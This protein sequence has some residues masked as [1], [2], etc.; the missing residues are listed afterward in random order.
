MK[1]DKNL[2]FWVR[3]QRP[4]SSDWRSGDFG[5]GEPHPA[6]VGRRCAKYKGGLFN[7]TL[8]AG[9]GVQGKPWK[10]TEFQNGWY[11]HLAYESRVVFLWGVRFS[12]VMVL[13][14]CL[15][16]ILRAPELQ[17]HNMSRVQFL[18]GTAHP[19]FHIYRNKTDFAHKLSPLLVIN[20]VSLPF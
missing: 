13:M 10:K 16:L 4:A 6:V 17:W 2:H 3:S 15:V 9:G 5:F 18:K 1:A 20:R 8:E 12:E 19:R 14:V 7:A 11:N